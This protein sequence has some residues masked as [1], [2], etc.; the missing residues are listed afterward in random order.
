MSTVETRAPARFW[1]LGL[2]FAAVPLLLGQIPGALTFS[3]N[4]NAAVD[5]GLT[6]VPIPAWVFTVVWVIAFPSMGI[7]AWELWRRR[8]TFQADVA[9]PLVL[10][11]IGFMQ[12]QS[13]WLTDSLRSTAIIDGTA[14]LLS[15]TTL[16]VF[17]RY[18]WKA[19]RWLLPWVVWMPITLTIK[20]AAIAGAFG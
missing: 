18:T 2:V 20:I 17:S 6:E 13:F 16:W 3:L 19:A 15:G 14:V 11:A 1:P 10:L 12:S 7:A 9:V 8:H 4:P 5:I